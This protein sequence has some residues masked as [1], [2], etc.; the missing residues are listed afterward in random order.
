[1][2]VDPKLIC[3]EMRAGE[4]L[5]VLQH[6]LVGHSHWRLEAATLLREIGDCVL[7]ARC[8]EALREVDARKREAEIM[9]DLC[10]G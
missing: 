5:V 6:A 1:M 2:T 4:L 3:A 10:D 8:T 9:G 7:P